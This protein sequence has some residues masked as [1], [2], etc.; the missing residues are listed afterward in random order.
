[1][2]FG[3][4]KFGDIE[5]DYCTE[6]SYTQPRSWT[7][8]GASQ[9]TFGSEKCRHERFCHFEPCRF[10]LVLSVV[11]TVGSGYCQF[12][13][14]VGDQDSG[15]VCFLWEMRSIPLPTLGSEDLHSVVG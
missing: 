11:P 14:C 8:Q 7:R 3:S 9:G 2:R 13:V 12:D 4:L 10:V 15:S 5:Q 6:A 1:M